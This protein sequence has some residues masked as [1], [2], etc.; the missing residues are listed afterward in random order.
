M[1]YLPSKL[2]KLR[3]HYNYSQSYLADILDVDTFEYM[4]YENGSKMIDYPQMKKLAS[5]YHL[6]VYDIFKN[7]DDVTL[8]VLDNT[9]DEINLEYFTKELTAFDKFKNY[10]SNHKLVSGIIGALSL[11]IVILLIVVGNMAKP[12]T[13]VK[14]NINRISASETTIIY[15]DDNGRVA[16]A[17][18]NT[19]GQLSNL[20]YTSPI[21]VSEG[22]G[23]TL[24]LNEDGTV[25][26]AGPVAEF[27]KAASSLKNIV[28]MSAGS[29]HFVAVDSNGRVSCFG[30]SNACEVAGEKNIK[31]VF[32]TRNSSIIEDNNGKLSFSGSVIGSSSLKDFTNIITLDSSDE[33]LAIL[34]S[35]GTISVFTK[36][37]HN[38]LV[39]EQWEEIVD[40]ACGNDF[41]AGLDRYG[42][43]HIEIQND[44]IISE[45]ENWSD[46]IAISAGSDYLVGFDG[47]KIVGVGNNAY[48]QFVKEAGTKKTLEK[49]NN[50]SY[51]ITGNTIDVTFNGV[52]NASGY[53][54]SLD[55]GTGLSKR[56]ETEQVVSFETDQMR[57]GKNYTISITSIGT[58]D[59]KDSDVN[60]VSF[61]FY[62]PVD[63]VKMDDRKYI[64]K[65]ID[66]FVQ[67][68][69]SLGF[70]EENLV[71]V[72]GDEDDICSGNVVTVS[73]TTVDEKTISVSDM[74][75]M[76]IEYTYCKVLEDE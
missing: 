25:N 26:Y 38:F 1:N 74:P 17:G 61:T 13:P 20:N 64:N 34:K 21:K 36:G 71:G 56:V 23:F 63:T 67:Y 45:I 16:G 52:D 53:L 37:S 41:V 19:N 8:E 5:L 39:A 69:V 10:V 32:A 60:S 75:N 51:V 68:M 66:T 73:S 55:V 65:D 7:S 22:D 43:V 57:E 15:I 2:T 46:I 54:V 49:V 47:K 6:S 30:E 40:V 12:Y 44:E 33:I 4:N 62:P 18:S 3:K 48:Q 27:E 24:I 50:I 29:S 42:K 70:K 28:D 35:D 11:T 9:T 59:Y 76:V 31:R 14:M 72:P 58:G